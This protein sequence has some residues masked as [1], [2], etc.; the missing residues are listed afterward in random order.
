MMLYERWSIYTA[1]MGLYEEMSTWQEA[2]P[3]ARVKPLVFILTHFFPY[4]ARGPSF[5]KR[6]L[7]TQSVPEPCQG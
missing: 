6:P 1:K 4:L 5:F 7:S 3:F 2:V